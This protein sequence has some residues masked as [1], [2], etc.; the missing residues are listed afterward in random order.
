MAIE[1]WGGDRIHR[2]RI[3]ELPFYPLG[4]YRIDQGEVCR[5]AIKESL[6]ER[7]QKYRVGTIV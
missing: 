4:Y 7:G 2:K 1:G 6:I 5:E 3:V